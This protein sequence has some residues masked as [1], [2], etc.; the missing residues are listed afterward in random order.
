[1]KSAWL[2]FVGLI[3]LNNDTSFRMLAKPPA[4]CF[5]SLVSLFSSGDA[6]HAADW[7]VRN[8]NNYVLLGHIYSFHKDDRDERWKAPRLNHIPQLSL[9]SLWYWCHG[10]LSVFLRNQ[11]PIVEHKWMWVQGLSWQCRDISRSTHIAPSFP[12]FL[13]VNHH[14]AVRHIVLAMSAGHGEAFM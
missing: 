8:L 7:V 11:F 14:I 10:F 6:D 3:C 5:P 2:L 1:M 4:N 9:E 12:F 13:A